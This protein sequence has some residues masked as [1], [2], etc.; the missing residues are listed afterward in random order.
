MTTTGIEGVYIETHNW[1]KTVA[2]W[3][4]LGFE[5]TFETD[6]HS[7][8]LEHP[9]GGPFLFVA[10][11]PADH[12]VQT[13]LIVAVDDVNTFT[14]DAPVVISKPFEP[15]HWQRMEGSRTTPTAGRSASR[16]RSP[17]G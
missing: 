14:P 1:G 6:H 12:E 8:Q 3:K 16:P 5:L 17:T 13:Q 2:F 10:E 7:G 4:A 11:R 9:T 15:T